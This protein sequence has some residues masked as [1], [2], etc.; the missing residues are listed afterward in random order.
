MDNPWRPFNL[1]KKEHLKAPFIN[2]NSIDYIMDTQETIMSNATEILNPHAKD[3][4]LALIPAAGLR[5]QCSHLV[6]IFKEGLGIMSMFFIFICPLLWFILHYVESLITEQT[7]PNLSRFLITTLFDNFR[8]VLGSCLPFQPK[9]FIERFF[10]ICLLFCNLII[11]NY[12]QSILV[13]ILTVSHSEMQ[14]NTLKELSESSVKVG[15]P[16]N[17]LELIKKYFNQTEQ[18]KLVKNLQKLNMTKYYRIQENIYSIPTDIGVIANYDRLKFL[19]EQRPVFHLMRESFVP[20]LCA[21]HVTRGS[22]YKNMFQ[23]YVTRIIEAGL[24]D[25]WQR[26]THDALLQRNMT[27]TIDTGGFKIITLNKFWGL[28]YIW[29]VGMGLS[30]FV[31]FIEIIFSRLTHSI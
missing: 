13:S 10:L 20:M 23:G 14:I 1:G 5:T 9:K 31:F 17:G 26:Q 18:N 21:Y 22:P 12:F 16:E 30:L 27:D 19:A 29:I 3:D 8:L 11:N 24:Y 6:Q 4:W 7:R 2:E 28:F 15:V 25:L